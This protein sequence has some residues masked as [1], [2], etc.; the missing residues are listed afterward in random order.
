MGLP[1]ENFTFQPSPPSGCLLME[2]EVAVEKVT[3]GMQ[4]KVT[5]AL[6]TRG[7]GQK[8]ELK[9]KRE[10][11]SG[12]QSGGLQLPVSWMHKADFAWAGMNPAWERI[13]CVPQAVSSLVVVAWS[14]SL[15]GSICPLTGSF[16]AVELES[17]KRVILC[18]TLR[19]CVT[20]SWVSPTRLSGTLRTTQSGKVYAHFEE[21]GI[22][23]LWWDF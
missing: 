15:L 20:S 13:A 9:T 6:E 14:S 23:R 4:G 12:L 11:K 17:W 18:F 10:G 3:Q 5:Q 22:I 16:S 7:C 8:G 21:S 19:K 1:A 2:S